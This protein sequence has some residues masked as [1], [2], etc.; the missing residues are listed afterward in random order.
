[1]PLSIGFDLDNTLI[2]YSGLF[3]TLAREKALVPGSMPP[4]KD[5]IRDHVRGSHGDT[6]WQ[7]LQRLAYGPRLS[8]AVL[9][10]GAPEVL[11]RLCAVGTVVWIIS[12]KTRFSSLDG[13]TDLHSAARTFLHDTDMMRLVPESRI[14]FAPDRAAKCAAIAASGCEAF[15]DDLPEVL[16]DAAFPSAVAKLFFS[17]R[18][19][20]SPEYATIRSWAAVEAALMLACDAPG[21]RSALSGGGNS[22][23]FRLTPA[24]APAV[25]LKRYPVNPDDPRDRLG[26]EWQGL[27]FLRGHGIGDIPEPLACHVPSGQAVYSFLP[28]S[29]PLP[30]DDRDIPALNAFIRE[31]YALRPQG[32]DLFP[33]SEACFC[34]EG[35]VAQVRGRFSRLLDAEPATSVHS[36]MKEWVETLFIRLENAATKARGLYRENGVSSTEELHPDLRM[37]SPS[38]FGLHN[39]LRMESGKLAFVDFEYFGLDDPAKLLADVCL[40]PG[41]RLSSEQ[42][43]LFLRRAFLDLADDVGLR[44]RFKAVFPLWALKWCAIVLNPFLTGA[45]SEPGQARVLE[46]RLEQARLLLS[47]H[48]A[49]PE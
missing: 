36:V 42:Q 13:K 31:L 2:D 43:S 26:A 41:M 8:E 29:A 35:I 12:H 40:H 17:P 45:S 39:A 37:P 46:N 6:A 1:M 32:K 48:T 33:A 44:T 5:L 20:L 38:D 3:L 34:L 47:T 28:G 19:L 25:C 7:E 21:E 30:P 10:P 9:F 49:V 15:M 27:S 16:D 18:G 11:Q 24:G 22:A 23:V 14:V 4:D